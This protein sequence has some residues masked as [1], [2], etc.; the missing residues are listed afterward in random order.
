[1]THVIKKYKR[2]S[3]F[4]L[5]KDKKLKRKIKSINQNI[6]R[7]KR[8]YIKSKELIN[9]QEIKTIEKTIIEQK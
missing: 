9:K 4:D 3:I 6:L 8:T 5:R 7:I 1:M 2:K